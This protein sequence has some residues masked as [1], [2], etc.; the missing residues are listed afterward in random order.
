MRSGYGRS[1]LPTPPGT[2]LGG[3]AARTGTA[4]GVLDEL[5]VSVVTVGRLVWVVADL[6][7]VHTDLA[8]AVR[9][10]VLEVAT[11]RD[12]WVSATHT[13]SGPE[14]SCSAD[15]SRTPARW[16]AEVPAAAAV[17]ARAAVAGE[18]DVELSVRRQRLSG[19]GG[20]RS[21]VRP[22][23]TVPVDVL[24]FTT[25]APPAAASEGVPGDASST[26]GGAPCGVLV[27]LPVHPTVLGADN[28]LVST[29]LAGAVRR[30]LAERLG[31]PWVVVATGAAGDVSTRPHRRAQTPEECERLG[32]L[33]ADSILRC[34]RKPARSIIPAHAAV[35][36]RRVQVPLPPKPPGEPAVDRLEERLR[37]AERG[38]DP[39]VIRTAWTALQAARLATGQPPPADPTCAV[40]VARIGPLSL[41]ALGA[42]P[43]LDLAAR[44]DRAVEGPAVLVGYTNG[45]L[46]YLPVREAYR[47][48]E[49][50]VLRSQV[51]PGG[52][53]HVLAQATELIGKEHS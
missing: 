12:V 15:T 19:V 4:T 28:L 31:G 17:A 49:Y 14:T 44:L 26:S 23:R 53:E 2:P 41:V 22:L 37:E 42:E 3:Y 40:S 8:E 35:Q 11:G 33:V 16:L 5:E 43:Y 7:Y 36:V 27:V 25:P 45:Y 47:H 52:A 50:E 34:L 29:D 38:G 21:G 46:G 10:A 30:A 20:Q 48:P 18:R 39:A 1:T 32:T 9:L 13:H 51:A 24:S 6:P